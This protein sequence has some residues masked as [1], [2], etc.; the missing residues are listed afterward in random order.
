MRHGLS[1]RASAAALMLLGTVLN[2][3]A[4]AQSYPNR[5][6]RL[7]VPFIAG[8]PVDALARLLTQHLSARLGQSFLIENQ[9]GA[10]GTL[11]TR[12]AAQAGPDGHTLLFAINAHAYGLYANPG[13]DPV[14]SF[15][16]VAAVAQWSHVLVVRPD[17]P[18]ATV[19]ELIAHAKAYPG[20]VTFGF[21][22]NTPPQ[23]LGGMLKVVANA[24]I[25]S[26]PYRGGAQVITDMLGGRIDMN[27]GATATLLPLIEQG[28]LRAIAY[29]GAKR[30]PDLPGVPT[31]AEAGYPQLAFAPDAWAAV[32]APAGTPQPIVDRL[33]AAI[34][35]SLKSPELQASLAKLGYEPKIMSPR[36]FAA[37]LEA[38]M[39]RWPPIAK[40]AGL[41]SN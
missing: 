34:N 20:S 7:I 27:F 17:F 35:E 30:S 21:G 8:S 32:L 12:A 28:K 3:S 10:G 33:N 14:G 40:A 36:E 19:G 11:G 31:I 38:E 22:V 15:A 9:S 1:V 41:T 39:R 16:P 18:A 29:T 23:I 37:F 5:P 25:R 4:P 26:I 13:Y 2:G 6:V 24:D